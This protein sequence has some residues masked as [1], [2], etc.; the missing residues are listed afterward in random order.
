M[1]SSASRCIPSMSRTQSTAGTSRQAV[2]RGRRS[3]SLYWI[4]RRSAAWAARWAST[5]LPRLT[6]ASS[7]AS[8]GQLRRYAGL[9][10]RALLYPPHFGVDA[11]RVHA[12]EL[13][14]IEA[15]SSWASLRL[16]HF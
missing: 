12:N 7:L 5:S 15:A 16:G 9:V 2:S 1:C 8:A 11:E 10:D 6:S 14:L 3:D 13:S 4:V